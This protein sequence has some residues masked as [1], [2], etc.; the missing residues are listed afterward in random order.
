MNHLRLITIGPSHYC[1]KARWALDRAAWSYTEEKHLPLL[2]W[3]ASFRTTRQRMV[4]ILVTNERTITD[5]T[6][7]IRYI[8]ARIA[9]ENRLFPEGGANSD[10]VR[11]MEDSFDEH[12]GTAARRWAYCILTQHPVVFERIFTPDLP[13]AERLVLKTARP[14]LIEAMKKAFRVS[15]QARV[16]MEEKIRGIFEDASKRLS[17][18]RPYLAGDRFTAADLTFASL[19]TPVLL[20]DGVG[21]TFP[22][23]SDVPREYDL[24]VRELSQT[25]AGKHAH[26]MYAE[27]RSRRA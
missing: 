8:D 1:E 27:E 21:H 24:F 10:E 13:R 12:L 20:P 17:D 16:R 3:F 6:E 19:A 22:P 23:R 2:H 7:I 4:P 5:S 26:R 25:T 14:L 15:D 9:R 11:A 18:G